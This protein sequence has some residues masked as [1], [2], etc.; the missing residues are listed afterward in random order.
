MNME[1]QLTFSS[2]CPRSGRL[3]AS[4]MNIVKRPLASLRKY[5]AAVL[6]RD[7]STQQT[8]WLL[9]AQVAFALTAF[10]VESPLMVRIA[11]CVWFVLSVL[12][13]R[14]ALR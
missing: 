9:E 10:P 12:K 4:I 8:R 3:S 2:G 14:K 7:I 1:N 13:C 6:G 5:Y 11:C